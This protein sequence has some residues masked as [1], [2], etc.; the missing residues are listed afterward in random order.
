MNLSQVDCRAIFDA[1]SDAI[2]IHDVA[3]GEILEV[4]RGMCEMFGYT[5]E[6]ARQLKVTALG[7]G[8]SGW[9]PESAWG[10]PATAAAGSPQ[11]F[12]W[13]ARD[14]AGR[15]FWVE[16][17]LKPLRLAG[18]DCILAVL[19]DIDQRKRAEEALQESET[20][21]RVATEGSLAGVY[22]LQDDGLVYVNPTMAQTFGYR[23]EEI[24]AGG[25]A[26][27]DLIH[28]EDLPLVQENIRRRLS[29]ELEAAHYTFRGL[30]RDGSVIHYESFGRAVEYQG[31]PAIVGTLLDITDKVRAEEEFQEQKNLVNLVFSASPDFLILKDRDL[32]YRAV[33]PAFCFMLG[34]SE[35]EIIGKTDYDLFP[36][37]EAAR[38]RDDDRKVMA[39]GVSLVQDEYAT[40]KGGARWFQVIKTPVTD[41]QGNPSGVICSVR[42]IS[43]RKQAEEAVLTQ[44]RVLESMAEGVTVTDADG[45]II[46][47]NPAFDAMFGYQPGELIGQPAS[48]LNDFSASE[49][50]RFAEAMVEQLRTKRIMSGEVRNRK[51]DGTKFYTR[52]RLSA[53]E[54]A[55]KQC[56]VA[57]QEDITERKQVEDAL[58]Q[59]EA[60]YRIVTEGSLAGV[61]LIQD[62]KFR[63]VNPVLAEA[64]GYRPDEIIDRLGPLDLVHPE[65]RDRIAGDLRRRLAEE[66]AGTRNSFKGVRQ[67][68]S[69]IFC[70]VLT[71]QVEYQGRPAVMGTLLDVTERRLAEEALKASEA[72][73]RTIFGAVND[74]IAVIDPQTGAFLQ[75][76][77]KF[78]ESGYKLEEVEHLNVAN[79]CSA[80]HPFSAQEGREW[81][82]K[83]V[84]EGPQV[85]DWL[86]EDKWGRR[87]WVEVSLTLTSLGGQDVILSV[88]RDISERKQAEDIRRRAYEELEQLV[89]ERTA[90]LQSANAQLRREIEE[91][92]RTEAIIRLQRDLALMLSGKIG[93]QET[94]R[95]CVETAIT[96]SGL[97]SGGVYLVDSD[98]GNLDLAYHQGFSPQFVEYVSHY[99]ADSLN[100]YIV[101]AAQPV[102]A[103][104]QDLP[105][106]LAEKALKEG[107]RSATIIPVIHQD[108]VIA[109]INIASHTYEEVPATARAALETLAAQVGSAIARVQA[110]EALRRSKEDLEIRVA[111]RTAQLQQANK[112]L[113]EELRIR[114]LIERSLRHSEA[115]YRS[116]VEQI[117]AITYIIS[118][119]DRVE[120]LYISP[121]IE[122]LLGFSPEAWRADAENWQRQIHPDDRERVLAEIAY[123]LASGEPYATEYRLLAKSGRVVWFR[124]E[125]RLV[126]DPDG[127]FRFL[128]GLALDITERKQA[129]AAL[130]ET[131]HTLQTLIQASPL[132]IITLDPDFRIS[133]WNPGA[134]RMFGWKEAEVLGG[135]LPVVPENQRTEEDGRLKLEMAGQAQSALELKR[136][137]KDG[138]VIDVHLWTASLLDA[139]GKIIG[140]MGI[141]AD[142]TARKRA[143]EAL[144]RQ[145]ELLELAHDAIIVRDLDNR[146][147]FW[148]SGAEETYGWSK[149]EVQG[150]EPHILLKTEFPQPLGELEAEFFRQGQW[151]G[152]LSHTRRDGRRI[153]VTSR[154][155]LQ[156]DKEGKPAAI[157]EINRDITGQKQ[158]EAGRARLA[159]ILEAT[160]DLVGTADLEGRVLYLNRAGRQMLGVGVEED[161]SHY[162]VKDLQPEWVYKLI[163]EQGGVEAAYHEVWSGETAFASRRGQEIPTS[164]VVIAHKDARGEVEFYSTIARDITES[165]RAAEALQEANN[166]LRTLVEA[167]PLAIIAINLER[168]IISWNPAAERMFGWRQE[169]VIGQVLPTIPKSREQEFA[170]LRQRNLQGIS[171]LGQ[172]LQRQRRDGSLIDVS[173]S[174]A[175]LHDGA[176]AT[177]GTVG[178][179]ED[180]TERKRMAE[181]LWQTSRA[182]K[183]IT[184]C[185]QALIRATNE[186]ELLNEVCRIIVEVGGYRMAWV[187]YAEEDACKSVR[188]VAQTGFD[189][190]YV[191]K[192]NLTWANKERGRG[193]TGKAI[194]SGKPSIC[195]NTLNDPDI[196]PWRAEA[197]KRNFQS[198]LALPLIGYTSFG[199]LTIY[200]AEPNAF[201]DE[202]INLLLGLANDLA[203]GIMALRGRA[204]Q[205]R[206]EEALKDSEHE[207]RLLTTRILSIQEEERRR[208]ARELHDELG[209]A[210]TV[211]KINLVAIED[212]LAPDQQPLKANCEH[213]LSYIDTVIEN[214]RRL[215]W[216]LSPS[217]LEDLGLS[218]ALGYL[219]DE[220]C[221]NHNMQSAVVMD[222]IDHLFP[223]EIQINIYRIFQESLTNVVKHARASLVSVDVKRQDGQVSF[224]IQDN[225]RGFNLGQA[226]SGKAAT[227]SLGLTAMNERVLMAHGALQISSRRGRG[228]TIAFTIPTDKH[229]K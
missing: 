47:S 140:N 21:Y 152:E 215:S 84:E 162:A 116:L 20:R 66:G 168:R 43:E 205:Q 78:L 76:N 167:S 197:R 189:E 153:V 190:G 217:S 24:M 159:A 175:P 98:S 58:R 52:A 216:D 15:V 157:L 185:R 224:M 54:I 228:T 219:V 135:Y 134:E 148:N 220:T 164:Q 94:L 144:R 85:Y 208:V 79:L 59:S 81:L 174:T 214:V 155:A 199:A 17:H 99:E 146:I 158:A 131:T 127:Q 194:R 9:Q 39:T 154:W 74:A 120:F 57:V 25:I 209:Q 112:S 187:G 101:M 46:Y 161:V 104:L 12:A 60:S 65:D 129:E 178:I 68:G 123:A 87:I 69:A 196:A 139:N 16:A 32:V 213:M 62:D 191:E 91:R 93:L 198:L 11:V 89:A 147:V 122:T 86:A 3:T 70:E 130:R 200:A 145:A 181:T 171:I 41:E 165:K 108:Q 212:K 50:L 138:S 63:Y 223:P 142:I 10:A 72:K 143:E 83:A 90:R 40:G 42:D 195:R 53:L 179:I 97:D 188:A 106:I 229:G 73:Y 77:Q 227:R 211:L 30:H 5:P 4:N 166:R 55:G 18:C 1:V 183:A 92:R 113:E 177:I 170:D 124:D 107:L 23:P 192:L 45:K 6:E 67:D 186:I 193:P 184:E 105:G 110:E 37:R 201:D 150:Q 49:G 35:E 206:A 29:G 136:V 75:V 118:L 26:P 95:L 28:P 156:R 44:T 61:Y 151:Q 96:I 225:G 117:P 71:R 36:G 173:L 56:W 27:K 204:E 210:L 125:A 51:K 207:L 218:A 149:A 31:R 226:M 180:I 102:Y 141:L 100:S 137:R 182:L 176:G 13:R 119:A 22:V 202:E 2:L 19:R 103:R 8:E 172:E 203:Y 14:R 121:Q 133:L 222:E 169:E 132:A 64:F 115:K 114:R 48:R 34:K 126:Y 163:L 88:T 82:R 111:E 221:R 33:N 38:Y 160:S 80:D 109:C 7:G 128:Q